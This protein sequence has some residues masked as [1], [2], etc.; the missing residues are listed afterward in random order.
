MTLLYLLYLPKCPQC[1]YALE[2]D[3]TFSSTALCR[4]G[5]LWG[6][7][8]MWCVCLLVRWMNQLMGVRE[9]GGTG[10][11][12]SSHKATKTNTNPVAQVT[13][14]V[15]TIGASREVKGHS[16]QKPFSIRADVCLRLMFNYSHTQAVC[17]RPAVTGSLR[18]TCPP[19]FIDRSVSAFLNVLGITRER[20]TLIS[21]LCMNVPSGSSLVPF[22]SRCA[23]TCTSIV[24]VDVL[25]FPNGQNAEEAPLTLRR[26]WEVRACTCTFA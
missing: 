12:H 17:W 3:L 1:P 26:H 11:T 19:S 20:H 25:M 18:L 8:S 6:K 24:L 10:T 9:D 14:K 22:H 5:P 4:V 2:M 21:T 7:Y 16:Q 13:V 23:A 15:V